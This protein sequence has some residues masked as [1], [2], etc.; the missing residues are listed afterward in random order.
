MPSTRP[1]RRQQRLAPTSDAK[2]PPPA[3][4]LDVEK[5]QAAY[6]AVGIR[7]AMWTHQG[8]TMARRIDI[9]HFRG[10]AQY[11]TT[12]SAGGLRAAYE[13]VRRYDDQRARYLD[14]VREDGE[15]G[16]VTTTALN[17]KRISRDLVDSI[18]EAYFIEE[19]AGAR[20]GRILDIGAGYG[21]LAHRLTTIWPEVAVYSTDAVAVST[22]IC[23]Y[24]LRDRGVIGRA[25]VI[26]YHQLETLPRIHLACNI[27]SWSECSFDAIAFWLEL[28]ERQRVPLLFVVPHDDDFRLWGREGS[29]RPLI[30]SHGYKLRVQRPKYV[31]GSEGCADVH[32][33]YLF[34]LR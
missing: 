11:L 16:V 7:H 17:G 22:A 27:H 24:Y 13:A 3:L 32:T 25:P 19:I 10:E 8:H 9:E 15:F 18:A 5:L 21:R 6:D 31:L 34:E 20:R 1:S 12:E 26:P 30:E 4:H 2:P 14:F 23:D 33:H 29:F 28:L